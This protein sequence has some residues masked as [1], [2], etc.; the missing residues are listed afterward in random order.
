MNNTETPTYK[1]VMIT[2]RVPPE[3]YQAMIAKVREKKDKD[4]R[5]YS[6]NQYLTELIQKDIAGKK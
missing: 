5:G 4:D 3:T 6:I 2:F 1:K